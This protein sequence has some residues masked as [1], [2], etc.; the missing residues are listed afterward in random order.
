MHF[1]IVLGF[2][3]FLCF[4]YSVISSIGLGYYCYLISGDIFLFYPD[5]L[6]PDFEPFQLDLQ[7][8]QSIGQFLIYIASIL[9]C[10]WY[11]FL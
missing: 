11:K 4:L 6:L 5:E 9:L 2:I 3:L 7:R 8:A 1:Y 10:L